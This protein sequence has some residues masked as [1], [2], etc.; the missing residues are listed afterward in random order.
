MENITIERAKLEDLSYILALQRSAFIT[1]ARLYDNYN[2]EPLKQTMESI[3][4]D[5]RN[6]LFLV[7]KDQEKIV[8]SVKARDTGEYCWIGRLMVDPEYRN[9]G[10]GK[11]L[12]AEIQGFFPN[13]KRYMLCTGNKSISNIKL[14]ESLGFNICGE[15]HDESNPT[16]EMVK[17][18]KENEDNL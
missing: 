2:L 15:V 17:M 9:M 8:G 12:M 4:E 6:Y 7:A 5:F 11:K 1:E 13:A 14:Y 18:V 3:G 10:I 16:V